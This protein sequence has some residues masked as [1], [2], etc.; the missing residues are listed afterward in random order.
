MKLMALSRVCRGCTEG[1]DFYYFCHSDFYN[2]LHSVPLHCVNVKLSFHIHNLNV[3]SVM[4]LF[5]HILYA[6]IAVCAC[7]ICATN[8]KFS[9]FVY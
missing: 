8:P 1:G 9:I 2:Y 6:A 3:S 4:D 5:R 7:S